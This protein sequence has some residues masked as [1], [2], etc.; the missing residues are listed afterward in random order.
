MHLVEKWNKTVCN[1]ACTLHAILLCFP[2]KYISG[3]SVFNRA[4]STE[5][6]RHFYSV[7]FCFST[8]ENVL[9][10]TNKKFFFA[11]LTYLCFFKIFSSFS[12]V[13]F[14]NLFENCFRFSSERLLFVRFPLPF[15]QKSPIFLK[16]ENSEITIIIQLTSVC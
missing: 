14:F 6:F 16:V 2:L 3:F 7:R 4:Q 10:I 12:L 13:G 1:L 8:I 5:K 9:V 11:Y 15:L